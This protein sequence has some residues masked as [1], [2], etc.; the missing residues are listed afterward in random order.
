MRVQLM[1][2]FMWWII[3]VGCVLFLL[4]SFITDDE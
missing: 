4:L 2:S 3:L 1:E